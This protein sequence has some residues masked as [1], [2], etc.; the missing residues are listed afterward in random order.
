MSSIP[1]Q[2]PAFRDRPATQQ[3][4]CGTKDPNAGRAAM[5]HTP[6][7]PAVRRGSPGAPPRPG[8]LVGRPVTSC[9]RSCTL[10]V[11]GV[12][13]HTVEQHRLHAVDRSDLGLTPG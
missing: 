6:G 10:V 5:T 13:K 1:C 4:S 9:P 11:T 3:P 7:R 12:T 2:R 8:R